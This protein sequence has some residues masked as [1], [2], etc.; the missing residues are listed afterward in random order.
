MKYECER[1]FLAI[2]DVYIK[3]RD[4]IFQVPKKQKSIYRIFERE[5]LD[6]NFFIREKPQKI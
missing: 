5:L 6:R 4:D 3:I 2:K 1:K